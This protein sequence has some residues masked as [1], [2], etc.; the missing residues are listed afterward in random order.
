MLRILV[1]LV[2]SRYMHDDA[3]CCSDTLFEWNFTKFSPLIALTLTSK[4]EIE[5]KDGWQSQL[6]VTPFRKLSTFDEH[7]PAEKETQV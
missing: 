1:L 4:T 6:L 5:D 3:M 7:T 2:T